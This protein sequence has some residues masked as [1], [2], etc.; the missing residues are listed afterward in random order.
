MQGRLYIR[1]PRNK[2]TEA[3]SL[4]FGD[5]NASC[6]ETNRRIVKFRKRERRIEGI[7][8]YAEEEKERV[9]ETQRERERE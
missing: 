7:D 1:I 6:V 8:E 4:F 9:K 5:A 2:K 3:K